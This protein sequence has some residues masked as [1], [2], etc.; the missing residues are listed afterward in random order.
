LVAELPPAGVLGTVCIAGADG[1]AGAAGA[2]CPLRALDPGAPRTRAAP[3]EAA[4]DGGC[5]G[6]DGSGSG[7]GVPTRAG[8]CLRVRGAALAGR[9]D[10]GCDRGGGGEPMV[11]FGPSIKTWPT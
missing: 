6:S 8:S 4:S 5:A 1:G 9:A 2:P 10:L 11:G 3:C 7:C